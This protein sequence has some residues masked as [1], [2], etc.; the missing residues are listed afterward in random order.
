[1]SGEEEEL[2]CSE[3]VENVESRDIELEDVAGCIAE[4]VAE[5]AVAIK[6]ESVWTCIRRWIVGGLKKLCA[7]LEAPEPRQVS[8]ASV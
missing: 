8:L 2:I 7:K 4:C 6:R 5:T 3:K 1:M